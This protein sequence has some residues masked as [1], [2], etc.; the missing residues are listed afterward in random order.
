MK[1]IIL[2]EGSGTR[3]DTHNIHYQPVN[4]YYP[5]KLINGLLSF[6]DFNVGKNQKDIDAHYTSRS[7]P[8]M[9]NYWEMAVNGG[10]E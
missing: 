1:G 8:L 7:N 6:G 9:E 5:F 4:N 2:A 3:I 10:I